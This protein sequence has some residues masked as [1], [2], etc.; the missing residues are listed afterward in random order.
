[1][2][3]RYCYGEL[4]FSRL[5]FYAPIFFRRFS[6]E[7]LHGQYSDYFGRLYGP[8]L[9]VFAIVSTL[10]NSMQVEMAV[11]QAHSPASTGMSEIIKPDYNKSTKQVYIDM[12]RNLIRSANNL[13]ILSMVQDQ[14]Y[15]NIRGLPS[16]VPDF[17][18]RP[19][20]QLD[21]VENA[22]YW[23]AS[24]GLTFSCDLPPAPGIRLPLK[25]IKVDRITDVDSQSGRLFVRAAEIALR[26]PAVYK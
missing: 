21:I 17:S 6:F 22:P 19:P 18:A 23:C 1:V 26:L 25:G 5:N 8:V 11:E 9:F 14:H 20:A 15:T 12:A 4:R 7:Q 13:A 10:L 16:W 3:D 24:G 2:S